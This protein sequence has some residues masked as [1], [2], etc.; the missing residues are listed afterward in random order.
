M[1]EIKFA[2]VNNV[3]LHYSQ[4]GPPDKPTIA[5]INPLGGDYRVW[6]GVVRELANDYAIIRY[7]K[8]GH[9]LSECPPGPYTI[10]DHANDLAGL[11]EFLEVDEVVIIAVSIGGLIALDYT[12]SHPQNV[13]ALV[14]GDT[15]AKIGSAE[16][17]GERIQAIETDGIESM[18]KTILS[19]WFAPDY[20]DK[21]PAEYEG[22]KNMLSR[23]PTA[24][25]LAS[26]AA[27]GSADLR[28]E[29][30]QVEVKT[31]VVCGEEDSATPPDLVRGLSDSLKN[32]QFELFEDCGHNPS[33]EQPKKMAESIKMFLDDALSD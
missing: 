27:L 10:R 17:W 12:I 11:L 33:I 23:T 22:Y 14:L 29:L 31:L 9:G 1:S 18:S 25:Y 30:H 3:V 2:K 5:F 6:D 21:Q 7:D 32:S 8:R 20:Q 24:G 4:I 16:Y 19:R 28:D 13:K 26:C 15:A